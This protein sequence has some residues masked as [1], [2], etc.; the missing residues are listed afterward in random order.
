MITLLDLWA[1]LDPKR[2]RRIPKR[3]AL[4]LVALVFALGWLV[5]G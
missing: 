4:L 5:F 3:W 1:I 2:A